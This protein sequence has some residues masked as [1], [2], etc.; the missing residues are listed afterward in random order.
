MNFGVLWLMDASNVVYPIPLIHH[1][2][3]PPM[4]SYRWLAMSGPREL[5]T[6]EFCSVPHL[7]VMSSCAIPTGWTVVLRCFSKEWSRDPYGLVL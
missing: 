1:F 6:F 3:Q 7:L 2:R 5:S 4:R